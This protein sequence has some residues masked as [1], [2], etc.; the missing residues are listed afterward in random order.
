M[1]SN[2]NEPKIDIAYFG[3]KVYFLNE[4]LARKIET[5]QIELA[6]VEVPINEGPKYQH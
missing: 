6:L 5:D 4:K 1:Q 3:K 2:K